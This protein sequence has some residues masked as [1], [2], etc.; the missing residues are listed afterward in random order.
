[1]LHYV[2]YFAM[3]R[4][5]CIFVL[6]LP[7]FVAHGR[8]CWKLFLHHYLP[9]LLCKLLLA[10]VVLEHWLPRRSVR[11]IVLGMLL[12]TSA[13]A[14]VALAPFTY[15]L[16]LDGDAITARKWRSSWDFQTQFL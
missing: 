10:P 1:L 13:A 3:E 4:K 16:R 6:R 7:L 5:V 9:A 15:A 2:P 8:C 14:F 12:V 11:L